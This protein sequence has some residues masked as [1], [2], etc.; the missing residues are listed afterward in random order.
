MMTGAIVVAVAIAGVL[1]YWFVFR[2]DAPKKRWC[3]MFYLT[4][5]T[6][7]SVAAV[8]RPDSETGVPGT[9]PNAAT[10]DQKLDQVVNE[11]IRKLPCATNDGISADPAWNDVY[12]VYRAVWDDPGR[13]PEARV[14]RPE[15]SAPT[16]TYF[17]GETIWDVGYAIDFTKDIKLFFE[18]AYDK[19]PADH[20]AVFFWGHA[21]G[22]AGFFQPSEKP[23]VVSPLVALLT[24]VIFFLTG[25]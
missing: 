16:A 8:S 12:V 20:Y 1:V 5:N 9:A 18:W 2:W 6:P 21:M 25:T 7:A 14:V 24:K 11:A 19:C 13:D 10:L 17:N 4:S 23:V 22:P 15:I 3:V